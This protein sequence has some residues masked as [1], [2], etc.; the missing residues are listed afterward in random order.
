[1]RPLWILVALAGTGCNQLLGIDELTRIDAG[2]GGPI[3]SSMMTMDAPLVDAPPGMICVTLLP[4]QMCVLL[5]TGAVTLGDINTDND[6]RCTTTLGPS[7]CAILADMITIP[8]GD[9]TVIGMKPLVLVASTTIR[10]LGTLD[11][12]STATNIAVGRHGAGSDPVPAGCAMAAG[13][14]SN[15]GGGGG[16]GG[17][18]GTKGGD[19]GRGGGGTGGLGAVGA[20]AQA[21]TVFRAGCRGTAGGNT[22]SGP[23]GFGG[24]ALY[25]RAGVSIE[26]ENRIDANGAGG[27]GANTGESGGGGGGSGGM[28]VLESPA[29]TMNGSDAQ[30]T[31]NGGGGGEGT[32]QTNAQEGDQS[33]DW[34]EVA[35]GGTGLS[36]NGGAGGPGAIATGVGTVGVIGV[37]GGN[38]NDG[39]GGGGGGGVGVVW[40]RGAAPTGAEAGQISPPAT[41][42]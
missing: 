2:G 32:V 4:S 7:V 10:V 23:G 25:L 40:I 22:V 6:S 37:S 1:M 3:D 21:P 29:I 35:V 15:D 11:A 9:N 41:M 42:K 12:G 27:T 33:E 5:P 24:G 16:A 18:F 13:Q 8:T 34:N 30:I 17:T 38:N 28:I 36:V 39:G 14:T 31:A 20:P 19:G 26:I